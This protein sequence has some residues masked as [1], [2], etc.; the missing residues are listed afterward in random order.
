MIVRVLRNVALLSL[1]AGLLAACGSSDRPKEISLDDVQP[2]DL[3]SGSELAGL[4]VFAKPNPGPNLTAGEEGAGCLYTP[5]S[6]G[7]IDLDKITN[8][9][10]D[11]WTDSPP[12][13]ARTK[14]LPRSNGFRVVE[15]SRDYDSTGPHANCTLYVDVASGQS[16]K[17]QVAENGEKDPPTC[18]TARRFVDAA[19][20][21]LTR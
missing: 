19:V 9:G 14:E 3:L 7:R 1:T 4:G 21:T 18:D 8:Y 16:L 6:G 20:K 2:C 11:R 13:H 10:V 12:G 5:K 15:V 17:V